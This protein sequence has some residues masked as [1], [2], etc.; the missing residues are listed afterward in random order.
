MRHDLVSLSPP[1]PADWM[2]VGP[3]AGF[4]ARGSSPRLPPSRPFGPWHFRRRTR[5]IQLRG[6]PRPWTPSG[7]APHSLLSPR[8]HSGRG[9]VGGAELQADPRFASGHLAAAGGGDGGDGGVGFHHG[10]TETQRGAAPSINF[11]V[12]PCPCGSPT[13]HSQPLP[14]PERSAHPTVGV[15]ED[16]YRLSGML[17]LRTVCNPHG[18]LS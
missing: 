13:R 9:T 16:R 17:T 18:C 14:N 3:A 10:G 8:L 4:L 2:N 6:Q 12:S 15:S 7:S 11:S 1:H 5:R